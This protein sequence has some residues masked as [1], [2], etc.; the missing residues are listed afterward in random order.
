MAGVQLVLGSWSITG[1]GQG[2]SSTYRILLV[3]GIWL[4]SH[5]SASPGA[6][7]FEGIIQHLCLETLTQLS[8]AAW[9]WI[10]LSVSNPAGHHTYRDGWRW[11]RI[12]C[13]GLPAGRGLHLPTPTSWCSGQSTKAGLEWFCGV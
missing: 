6:G 3:C 13:Y 8:Q 12:L 10:S 5:L 2:N 11:S 4:A 9:V 7:G 1:L